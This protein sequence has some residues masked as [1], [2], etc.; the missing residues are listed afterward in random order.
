MANAEVNPFMA[1]EADRLIKLSVLFKLLRWKEQQV[2]GE[3]VANIALMLH[4]GTMTD[5]EFPWNEHLNS[6]SDEL[7]R[8]ING[9]LDGW[10]LASLKMDDENKIEAAIQGRMTPDASKFWT[11]LLIF[12]TVTLA[13]SAAI[14]VGHFLGVGKV[15]L[16]LTHVNLK[17]A[18]MNERACA[19]FVISALALALGYEKRQAP[20]ALQA[21]KGENTLLKTQQVDSTV[22][23]WQKSAKIIREKESRPPTALNDHDAMVGL[24]S[25][26]VR[27]EMIWAH[28]IED[29]NKSTLPNN[30]MK[31]QISFWIDL[32]FPVNITTPVMKSTRF[33]RSEVDEKGSFKFRSK[34]PI[35]PKLSLEI[36]KYYNAQHDGNL[37]NE[38]SR[39]CESAIEAA[40]S[41]SRVSQWLGSSR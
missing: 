31:E 35:A 20:K 11:G 10:S 41:G 4:V 9:H 36:F 25:D 2:D 1:L 15:P 28:M 18:L 39:L 34:T 23:L 6:T 21:L 16:L 8:A 17:P 26:D 24:N 14:I 40:G 30:L 29:Y 38:E 12:S 7:L 33:G 22:A 32:R 5:H 19:S 27:E 13:V 3:R 37:K